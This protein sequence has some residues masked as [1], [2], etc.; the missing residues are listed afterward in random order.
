[1]N[2][3]F[4][5]GLRW[6]CAIFCILAIFLSVSGICFFA[7]LNLS[8]L[9]IHVGPRWH[10]Y[11][12][13][14]VVADY[15]RIVAY[16]QWWPMPLDFKELPISHHALIHFAD[17][18]RLIVIGQWVTLISVIV[19]ITSVMYQKKNYQLWRL[20]ILFPRLMVLMIVIVGM[21][22]LS[23]ND[24]FIMMHHLLFQNSYWVFSSKDDP[25]ILLMTT[26]FFAKL[27]IVWGV[28]TLAILATIWWIL[29]RKI[30]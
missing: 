21:L 25:V 1:M 13:A 29:Y 5:D 12:G 30:S 3:K 2:G 28:S 17:V 7:V 22:A 27:F 6:F 19:S 10:G 9:L 24:S 26:S 8:P 20:I 11:S 18:K 15:H 14:G 4:G 16:L 23:F